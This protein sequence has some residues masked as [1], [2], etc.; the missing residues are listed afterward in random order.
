[1]KQNPSWENNTLSASIEMS[2][3][4]WDQKV[5]F[6]VHKSQPPDPVYGQMNPVKDIGL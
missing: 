2:G 5:H 4:V 3:L 6:R 1:M